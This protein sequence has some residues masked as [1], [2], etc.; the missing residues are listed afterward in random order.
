MYPESKLKRTIALWEERFFRWL[1]SKM[2]RN[3]AMM[4]FIRVAE[5]KDIQGESVWLDKITCL[6]ALEAWERGT[7]AENTM[8]WGQPAPE[9]TEEQEEYHNDE[10]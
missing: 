1:V 4:A 9:P 2:P 7:K 3:L 5:Q 8:I 10:N 6:E